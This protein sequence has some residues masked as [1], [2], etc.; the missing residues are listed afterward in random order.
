M[1]TIFRTYKPDCTIDLYTEAM[2]AGE[3]VASISGDGRANFYTGRDINWGKGLYPVVTSPD[4]QKE[5][6]LEPITQGGCNSCHGVTTNRIW[7]K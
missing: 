6:M 3:L 4:G 2:A 1:M 5:M 7:V